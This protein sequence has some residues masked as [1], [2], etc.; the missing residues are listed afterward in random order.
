MHPSYLVDIIIL[1]TASVI[2]V[3]FFQA[4]RLGAVP[5]F[6]IAGVV[7]G[8]SCLGLIGNVHEI[9]YLSEIGVVLL[10]FV[11]GIELKPSRLWRMRQIVFGLGSLQVLVTGAALS[12]LSYFVFNIPLNASILIGPALALSSTA[13]VLQLLNEQKALSSKYGR[14]SFAILLLQD[15]AVVPLLALIPL[16]SSQGVDTNIGFALIKSLAILGLIILI[17]RYF[18]HPILHR[19][20]LAKNSEVFTA[21]A[22]LIVLGAAFILEH[23]GLSQAMGAFLAG[24]LI[25]DSSYKHQVM[26]EIQPFRGLLLGLFF[27][28]MGMSFNLSLLLDNPVQSIAILALL[29]SIKASILFPLAYLFDLN[30]K[31]GLAVALILAQSG[32]FALVLFSLANKANLL[33]DVLFQQLLLLVLLSMIVTPLLA[34]LAHRLSKSKDLPNSSDEVEQIP[35]ND[36]QIVLA[37]FGRVGH[38]IGE[39]L[40]LSDYNFVAL[41]SDATIVKQASA[42]GFPVFYGDIRNPAVLKSAGA[43]N[44]KAIIITVNDPEASEQLVASLHTTHPDMKIFVR[45]HSLTQCKELRAMGASGAISEYVEVSIEL[46][47]MAL[48]NI[49]VSA[50]KQRRVLNAFREKYY[51]E[52]DNASL[53]KDDA[54]EP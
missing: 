40:S 29:I 9:S 2:A 35:G 38:R 46:S 4:I 20:A 50:N 44:A 23:I 53:S 3:P 32:E 45:G 36:T 26:A 42:D 43:A 28:S 15:L 16:L 31:K 52:I 21:S 13:F 18:L 47:R 17:G 37:G 11:I 7:V 5:G 30:T 14:T 27:M 51:A 19:V 48:N 8:P 39:I 33:S 25:S 1:L 24:L 54:K 10:L 49:G 6:L 22:L 41:D 12:S 34:H